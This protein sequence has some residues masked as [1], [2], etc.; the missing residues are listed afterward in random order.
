MPTTPSSPETW[1]LLADIRNAVGL[2]SDEKVFL[3][4]IVTHQTHKEFGTRKLVMQRT[5]LTDY[6]F[7]KG[8]LTRFSGPLS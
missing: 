1:K 2:S 5:G 8:S 6:K 7:R 4:N 3:Y